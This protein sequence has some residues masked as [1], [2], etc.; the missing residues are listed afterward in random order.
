MDETLRVAAYCRVSTDQDDQLNSLANQKKYFTEYINAHPGWKLTEIYSDEGISGTS[1]QKRINFSRMI[2]DAEQH[3]MD[4]ILTKEVSR[5]ARNTMDTLEYTRRLKELNI[6]VVFINDNIN[7]SV[8][9][10]EF[11]LTLMAALAQKESARTSERVKWGQKRSM[12][13]GVV[14]GRD[15]LGYAVKDGVLTVNPEEARTVRL[16]FHK[17]L[18]EGKGTHVIARE[19][20]EEGFRPKRGKQWSN[21]VILRI[22]RNEKYAGDLVQQKTYTPNYLNHRKKR[23]TG[24]VKTVCITNHH[25][26][27]IDRMTWEKAQEE[28]K[29]RSPAETQKEKYSNR[30]WCSGK[31]ICGECGKSFVS[32]TKKRKDGSVYHTWRCSTAVNHGKTAA[33]PL[34]RRIACSN[35]SVSE[36]ALCACIGHVMRQVP[37]DKGSIIQEIV[38]EIQSVRPENQPFDPASQKNKISALENKKKAAIDLALNKTISETDLKQQIQA[39]NRGIEFIQNQIRNA[40]HIIRIQRKQENEIQN[41]ISMIQKML[42]FEDG[43]ELLYHELIDKIMICKGNVLVI[44]LNGMP[45]SVKLHYRASGRGENYRAAPDSMEIISFSQ[46]A[47]L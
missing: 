18:N 17:F 28:L 27:I 7:T 40:D 38:R 15:L 37:L 25:E 3:K 45:F 10:D 4:L 1:T 35:N 14:F 5:F 44:Q 6:C 16:I 42:E 34:G 47:E 8:C 33:D 21:T 39:Y 32:R 12:E 43:D 23:N 36:K 41:Y 9:D 20:K 31:L 24:A 22:L 26:P 46:S 2:S 19:L 30:Y 13:S 29:H 11:Q